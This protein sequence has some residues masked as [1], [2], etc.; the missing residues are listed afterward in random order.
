M[1]TS[2]LEVAEKYFT[3]LF[4]LFHKIKAPQ[5]VLVS[6]SNYCYKRDMGYRK[7]EKKMDIKVQA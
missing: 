5:F 1:L 2:T 4:I 7:K 6:L 3:H